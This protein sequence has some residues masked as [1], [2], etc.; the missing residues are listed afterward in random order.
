MRFIWAFIWSF[1]L[2]QMAS[3][4]ISS[5]TGSTYDFMQAT[6]MSLVIGVLVIIVTAV[7]PNE[8]AEQHH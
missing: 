1:F 7:L 8:P 5:M 6:I 3:Y 2:V 4:V